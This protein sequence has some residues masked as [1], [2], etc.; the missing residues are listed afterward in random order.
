MRSHRVG[1]RGVVYSIS[2]QEYRFMR[3]DIRRLTFALAMLAAPA[4]VFAQIDVSITIAPPE[5]PVDVQPAMPADGYL[6]T[7]GYWAYAEEGYYWVPGAWVQ[8]PSVGVLWTPGYW[9]WSNGIYA[10]NAGYWG[11]HI[12]FYG[13]VNYGYGYGGDGYAGGRWNNGVFSYNTSVNNIRGVSVHNTYNETVINNTSVNRVSF[14][15]GSDGI[16]AAPTAEQQ[17]FAHENQIA[18]TAVQTQHEQAARANPQHKVSVNPGHP[19]PA[20][21]ATPSA[22][23]AVAQAKAGPA[24]RP[25]STGQA[26]VGHAN[27]AEKAPAH[28]AAAAPRVVHAAAPRPQAQ[29]RPVA[30]QHAAVQPRPAAEPH[31]HPAEQ[32]QS[33]AERKSPEH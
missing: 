27:L 14:N 33:P 6:W 8:P 10:F 11:P 23:K 32:R 31:Q 9:G 28:P 26:L 29:P 15:G 5:L 7:P 22:P 20:A 21:A 19:A 1:F 16:H 17:S 13:G 2:I 18:A 4:A 3:F 25:A 24:K 30:L 12:G